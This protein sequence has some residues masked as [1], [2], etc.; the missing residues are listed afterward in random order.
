MDMYDQGPKLGMRRKRNCAEDSAKVKGKRPD[1]CFL[2]SKA[3]LFKGEDKT[4]ESGLEKAIEELSTK[5]KDWGAAVHGQ[6]LQAIT[7]YCQMVINARCC[8]N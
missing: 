4:S 3:L 2:S 7:L 1:F 8:M 5:L 6:V